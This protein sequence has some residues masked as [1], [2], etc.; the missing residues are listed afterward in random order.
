[1]FY[2]LFLAES[3]VSQLLSITEV[4]FKEPI[5]MCDSLC[6][7]MYVFHVLAHLIVLTKV[8]IYVG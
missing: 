3:S 7:G 5:N 6:L 4:N 2:F 1:M 8:I